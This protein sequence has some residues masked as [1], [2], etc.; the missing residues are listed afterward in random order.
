METETKTKKIDLNT[1][2]FM[3]NGHK[4]IIQQ[5]IPVSRYRQFKKLTLRLVYGMDIKTLL[6]NLSKSYNYCDSPTPKPVSAGMIIHNVINGLNDVADDTRE[7]A[8]LLICALIIFREG[9]DVGVYDE[10]LCK[11][12]IADWAKEGYEVNGFFQLALI[13]IPAFKETFDLFIS[14]Q[15][16]E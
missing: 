14:Q 10:E 11:E 5:S 2:T 12:K 7:D 1:G 15:K 3:A 16:A 6:Q 13:S 8:A 9:E 4:Y